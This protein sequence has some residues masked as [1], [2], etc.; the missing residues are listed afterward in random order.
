MVRKTRIELGTVIELQE[1]LGVR[2]ERIRIPDSQHIV[3]L[4]FRR[5]AGCPV[6]DLHLHS[7]AQ[8]HGELLAASIRE[9]AV[10]H[11]TVEDLLPHA[12]QLPFTA[13]A[14]PDKRL[15]TEFGVESAPRALL[16]PRAWVPVLRG[17]TRSLVKVVRREQPIPTL[18]PHG[19]RFGLPADF[20]IASDG[21]VIACKYGSHAYDQWSVDEILGLA[22]ERAILRDDPNPCRFDEGRTSTEERIQNHGRR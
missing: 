4:Q 17:V 20:L 18:N 21:E 22:R 8:R 9:V 15:Y 12:R 6:C 16:D 19:G 2:S 5:F 1:L 3:H 7:I 11:S 14:D 13:I 10:F